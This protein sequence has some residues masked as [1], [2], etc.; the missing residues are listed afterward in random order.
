MENKIDLIKDCA[1]DVLA[2]IS[3]GGG[4]VTVTEEEDAFKVAIIGEDLGVLIGFHG[5]NIAAF[6]TVLGLLVAKRLGEWLHLGVDVGGYRADRESKLRDLAVRT[7][8]RVRFLQTSVTLAPM[9]AF[10]R[11]LIHLAVSE[12][13]G[14]VS[15]S[16]G[17][18]WQRRVVVKPAEAN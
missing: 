15:D 13:E 9:P 4:E 8:E 7:S 1:L 12:I 3:L 18:G 16:I 5:E 17:E 10:E 11:R 6:Q 2:K 14:V